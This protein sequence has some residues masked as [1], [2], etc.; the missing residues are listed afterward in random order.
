VHVDTQGQLTTVHALS[1]VLGIKLMPRIRNWKDLTFF[2]RAET[3]SIGT[4]TI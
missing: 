1:F 4:S 3:R 2:A